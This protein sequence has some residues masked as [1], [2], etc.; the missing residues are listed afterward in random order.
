MK[1]QNSFSKKKNFRNENV[2][3]QEL[4]SDEIYRMISFLTRIEDPE[5]IKNCLSSIGSVNGIKSQNPS[6]N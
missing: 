4:I 1:S 5:M 3:K 6:N 2:D